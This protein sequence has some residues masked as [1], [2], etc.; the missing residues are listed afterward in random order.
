MK[1]IG[2]IFL[3]VVAGM[4]LLVGSASA[5]TIDYGVPIIAID[6]DVDPGVHVSLFNLT[7]GYTI[8]YFLNGSSSFTP[9][10]SIN[11]FEGGDIINIALF[12]GTTY[13]TLS[14]DLGNNTYNVLMDFSLPVTLG[15]PEQPDDWTSDY[16]KSVNMQWTL[17]NSTI[18]TVSFTTSGLNDGIAPDPV[19]EPGTLLLLGTGLIGVGVYR[20]RRIR[21]QK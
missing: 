21:K 13:Y 3:M 9:F 12:D 11:T 7:T 14:G 18:F 16:F 15:S 19:P 2:L 5:L 20:W 6:G 8:G 1:K 17:P 10:S 4:F